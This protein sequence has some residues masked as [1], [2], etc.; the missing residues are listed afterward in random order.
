MKSRLK[1]RLLVIVVAFVATVGSWIGPTS[2]ARAAEDLDT[3]N[4]ARLETYPTDS[5]AIMKDSGTP[6]VWL[7]FV[8]MSIIGLGG[9]FMNAKRSNVE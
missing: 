9:M 5:N 2:V 4:D 3:K 7:V 8:F 1:P 6:G